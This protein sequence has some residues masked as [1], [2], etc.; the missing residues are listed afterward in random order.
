VGFAVFLESPPE[1]EP[2]P[3]GGGLLTAELFPGGVGLEVEFGLEVGAGV[4]AHGLEAQA[5]EQALEAIEVG[6]EA[7]Q[8]VQEEFFQGEH[9]GFPF[10]GEMRRGVVAHLPR[11]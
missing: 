9:G 1:G 2:S 7:G 11:A 6:F 3:P 8:F 5:V 10:G 4:F